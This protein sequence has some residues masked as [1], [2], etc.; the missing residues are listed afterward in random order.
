MLMKV[1]LL[2]AAAFIILFLFVRYLER[3]SLYF[4]LREIEAN[5]SMIGLHYEDVTVRTGDGI[6]ICGW[7]VPADTP[8]ATVLFFHGNGG[9][10]G[11]RLE[12]IRMLNQLDLGV[13]I[14]DYRGYGASG[15]SPSEKGLYDDAVTMYTYLVKERDIPPG[16]VIAYGESLGGAVAVDLA[17]TY[18]LGGVII[19]G[20]FTSVKDMA[21]RVLPFVPSFFYKTEYNSLK[22]IRDVRAP[23]LVVH[24]DDD[25][26]VPFHHGERLYN[27][28]REPKEFVRLQGGHNDAFLLSREQYLSG[29][30]SFITRH[31]FPLTRL[32][33]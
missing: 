15:G 7:Y 23:L 29:I 26:I 4:P 19:E 14:F 16:T 1:V 18:E 20:G 8:R 33:Q 12:K 6:Q 24:S 30:D 22:K 13:L 21:K 17:R 11:H 31:R 25:E 9:N 3:Q 2:C 27:A 32:P 5:P 10:I 28:A